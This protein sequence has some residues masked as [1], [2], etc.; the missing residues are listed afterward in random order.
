MVGGFLE[1]LEH[2]PILCDGA[3]GTQLYERGGAASGSCLDELNLS[4]TEL[5]KSIHLD[6]IQ[7]GAYF[8]PPFGRYDSVIQV[9]EGVREM[10][11]PATATDE[12]LKAQ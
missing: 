7:A 1:R 3:M 11:G 10:L 4:C 6:Y 2:G 8:M 12:P 9:L 5:V